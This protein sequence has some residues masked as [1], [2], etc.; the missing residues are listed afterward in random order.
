LIFRALKLSSYF[1]FL[2]IGNFF[3]NQQSDSA[4]SLPPS[5]DTPNVLLLNGD[6]R[7][8]PP[9]ASSAARSRSTS[10]KD[11]PKGTEKEGDKMKESVSRGGAH[12]WVYF[13]IKKN[14]ALCVGQTSSRFKHL[15]PER[16][17]QQMSFEGMCV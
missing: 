14:L 8:L 17:R 3:F 15:S 10:R 16:V 11:P 12:V 13:D 2:R 7:I 9:N 4:I 5:S 6:I 1:L